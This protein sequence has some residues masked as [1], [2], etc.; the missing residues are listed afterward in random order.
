MILTQFLSMPW[1]RL[2]SCGSCLAISPEVKTASRY[3]HMDCTWIHISR[4]SE[5]VDSRTIHSD[6]SSL[7][8]VINR[9]AIIE[10]SAICASSSASMSSPVAPPLSTIGPRFLNWPKVSVRMDQSCESSPILISIDF[11]LTAELAMSS[12]SCSHSRSPASSSVDSLN[13]S[14]VTLS[15]L[16]VRSQSLSQWRWRIAG[17]ASICTSGSVS[18]KSSTVFLS[19]MKASHERRS[20]GIFLHASWNSSIFLSIM[21]IVAWSCTSTHDV[22]L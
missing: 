15:T 14:E 19:S 8:G 18:R 10:P 22:S 11:S 20:L 3:C 13:E 5:M 1:K 7:K 21:S 6:A 2:D 12:T 17:L 9:E 16:P 4:I